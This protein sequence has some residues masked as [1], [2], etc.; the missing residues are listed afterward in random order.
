MVDVVDVV[1]DRLVPGRNA[2]A[3]GF[4]ATTKPDAAGTEVMQVVALRGVVSPAVED[5]LKVGGGES[6]AA[7]QA[8]CR[9]VHRPIDDG[10]LS[11][12][13]VLL[14]KFE[15]F[16]EMT[17]T[18]GEPEGHWLLLRGAGGGIGKFSES[19]VRH[20]RGDFTAIKGC[21][22]AP[23]ASRAHKSDT[24]EA[25]AAGT[26]GQGGTNAFRGVRE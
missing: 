2:W 4:V 16:F 10:M 6:L 8:R 1:V 7:D 12:A 3:G 9:T 21:F 15:G 5:G 14:A 25:P 24:Q 17:V 20:G 23:G 19:S 11:R 26:C 18:A 22:A 13:G